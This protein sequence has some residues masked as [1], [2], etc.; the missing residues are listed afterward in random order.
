MGRTAA[1]V[2]LA[3]SSSVLILGCS[4]DPSTPAYWEAQLDQAQRPSEKVRVLENL[5]ASKKMDKSFVPMLNA[6]MGTEK[7][8]ETK[9]VIARALGELKDSSSVDPLSKA[10]EVNTADGATSRMNAAIAQA[11]GDIG[12]PRGAP[13]LLGLLGTRDD[14]VRQ[15]AVAALGTLKATE[16]VP[17]LTQLALD[18]RSPPAVNRRAV[19]ALGDIGDARAVPTLLKALYKQRGNTVFAQEAS[20]SLFQIGKP[21]ADALTAVLDGRDRDLASWARS[22]DIADA[23]LVVR[24]AEALG[25][26]QAPGA[27][28][29]LVKQLSYKTAAPEQTLYARMAAAST[30]GKMRSAEG[31]KVLE[32]MLEESEPLARAEYARA[33]VLAGGRDALPAL[34]RSASKGPWEARQ[35]A[36]GALGMLGDDREQAVLDRLAADEPRLTAADCKQYGCNLPVQEVAA[37]RLKTLHAFQAPLKAG[38][39]C[40]SDAACWRAKLDDP[41]GTV[42]QR[43]ALELGRMGKPEAVK[44]LSDHLLDKE[45]ETR[46]AVLQ[47]LFWLVQRDPGAAKQLQPMV[48]K[49]EQ[50]YASDRGRQDYAATNEELR[51]LTT[52]VRRRS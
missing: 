16:A 9:A 25:D 32:G 52:E 14:Y 30:L 33:L 5:R 3:L 12:D 20:F 24:A 39:L 2:V 18:D 35:Y 37:N 4:K 44:A 28:K 6:H 26:F 47:A 46:A 45:P 50:Q 27:E 41:E 17:T 36:I 43:A 10:L 48:P 1:A 40:K 49:L 13:A 21:A 51:R 23:V 8:P 38:A 7:S 31:R 15:D 42:R 29:G 22:N 34:Q 11:L 19:V